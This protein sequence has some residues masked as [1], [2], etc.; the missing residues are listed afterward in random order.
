MLA[1]RKLKPFPPSCLLI[2]SKSSVCVCMHVITN[3]AYTTYPNKHDDK[4]KHWEDG[5]LSFNVFSTFIFFMVTVPGVQVSN[6]GTSDQH[7]ECHNEGPD[8][9][10]QL[11]HSN[12]LQ[13]N[14]I[15]VLAN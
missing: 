12:I 2:H 13:E 1:C 11:G 9:C 15:I 8:Q 7:V 6:Q 10:K 4:T 14:V 5:E 3:L